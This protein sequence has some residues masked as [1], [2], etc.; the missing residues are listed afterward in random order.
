MAVGRRWNDV[1]RPADSCN[2]DQEDAG[3]GSSDPSNHCRLHLC[4][5]IFHLTLFMYWNL[6]LAAAS[7]ALLSTSPAEIAAAKDEKRKQSLLAVSGIRS[8]PKRGK[9]RRK[10][11][12]CGY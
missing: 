8:R 9:T 5:F 7:P 1:S 6:L 10:I 4:L 3:T 12:V 2:G 11:L